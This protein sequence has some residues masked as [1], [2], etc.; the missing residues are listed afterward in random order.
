MKGDILK[1]IVEAERK[2]PEKMKYVFHILNK[3]GYTKDGLVRAGCEDKVREVMMSKIPE[4]KALFGIVDENDGGGN[5]G[6]GIGKR[7]RLYR[8]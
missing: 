6:G 7:R 8:L 1:S 5:T 3:A 4:T 2:Y